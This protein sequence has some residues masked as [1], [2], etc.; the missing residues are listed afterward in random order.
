M[1]HKC[2]T[3]QQQFA[4]RQVTSQTQA[5][6]SASVCL[7][8][9]T[10]TPHSI[11][12]AGY[13]THLHTA[14]LAA[15]SLQH[16]A[17]QPSALKPN[18]HVLNKDHAHFQIHGTWGSKSTAKSCVKFKYLKLPVQKQSYFKQ[19]LMQ[20]YDSNGDQPPESYVDMLNC[21]LYKSA[22]T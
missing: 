15:R 9:R 1:A 18:F 7:C 20:T 17:A 12:H 19:A 14:A 3:P 22:A 21:T 11:L 5:G 6:M 4:S 13:T 10:L 16:Y 2:W 8:H